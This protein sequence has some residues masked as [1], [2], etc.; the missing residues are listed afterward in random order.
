MG[1]EDAGADDGE[2]CCGSVDHFR[3]SGLGMAPR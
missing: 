1:D 2:Q 3:T